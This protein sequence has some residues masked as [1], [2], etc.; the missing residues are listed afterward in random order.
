L[1]DASLRNQNNG[2][3]FKIKFEWSD[4]HKYYA[5]HVYNLFDEWVLSKPPKKKR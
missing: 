2:K 4:K 3:T 1:G 5:D